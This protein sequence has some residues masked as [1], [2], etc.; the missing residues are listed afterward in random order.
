VSATLLA[1]RFARLGEEGRPA[2][3]PYL[4]VGFPSP[5]ISLEVAA[6]ASR[7]GAD[8]IEVGIPFSDPLADG[9][10]IQRATQRAL[11]AGVRLEHAFE[12]AR[13]VRE[14]GDAL[15]VLMTYYNPVHHMGIDRFLQR[16]QEAGAAGLIVPDLPLEE[17]GALR[18]AARDRGI[19]HVALLAPTTP[20]ERIRRIAESAGGFLYL[21]AV[22]GVTGT[23]AD[24]DRGL[25]GYLARV[26]E[27]TELPL[28]VGFGISTP[29]QGARVGQLAD[30]VIVGSALVDR[31][32]AAGGREAE[33]MESGVRAYLSALRSAR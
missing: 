33:A 11:D 1:E 31:L 24:L 19:D 17:A 9:P 15:P 25:E 14:S 28:C 2:F 5:E 8:V 29:E 18:D 30:G 3:C 7:A 22:T 10:T 27:Q 6:A 12:A 21:V 4:A 13:V 32:E 16:A 23:R 20:P 26:R